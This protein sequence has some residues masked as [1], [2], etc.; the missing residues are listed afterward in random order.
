MAAAVFLADIWPTEDEIDGGARRSAVRP[1][2]FVGLSRTW[3]AVPAW[4]ALEA[5]VGPRFPWDAHSTYLRR[6]PFVALPARPRRLCR[7]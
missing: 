7:S 3:P 4:A 1:A 5:P 6:P 2:D